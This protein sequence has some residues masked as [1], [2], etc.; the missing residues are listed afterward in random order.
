[1]LQ[2]LANRLVLTTR[3][4]LFALFLLI[5]WFY[6]MV[7]PPAV[8]AEPAAAA[9]LVSAGSGG[10]G[11]NHHSWTSD[12][13]AD[14]RLIAFRSR[15]TNLVA[16]DNTGAFFDIFVRDRQSGVT[17]RVSISSGG[18]PAN[19]ESESPAISGDGRVI[20]FSSLASNLVVGDH[21]E[22]ADVFVH[23]R[24]SG[25]TTRVSVGSGGTEGVLGGAAHPDLSSDGRFVVFESDAGNLIPSDTN[26]TT[27]IFGHDRATGVT[28]RLSVASDG[29]EG[30]TFSKLPSVSDNGQI[31]AFASQAFTLVNNDTNFVQDIFVRDR[32]NGLTT[33]VSVPSGGGQA[34]G[35]STN[36]AVSGDGRYVVFE[37]TATN[38]VVGDTNGS[39]DIFRHD[40]QTGQ[41]IRISTHQNG[42]EGNGSSGYPSISGDGRL[43]AFESAATNLVDTDPNGPI[44]DIFVKHAELDLVQLVTLDSSGQGS[45]GTSFWA[46]I[47][48]HGDWVT[49]SSDADDLT[50]GD[51]N[52]RTDVFVSEVEGPPPTWTLMFYMAADGAR[53]SEYPIIL[54]R[55]ESVAGSEAAELFVYFDGANPGD[56]AFYHVLPDFNPTSLASYVEGVNMFSLGEADFSDPS[57]LEQFIVDA[58]SRSATPHTAL[59]LDGYGHG[60]AGGM[61]D[62]DCAGSMSLV[63]LQTALA[64]AE[65]T[66][67]RPLDIVMGFANGMGMLEDAHLLQD[68]ASFWVA[69]PFEMTAWPAFYGDL[70]TSVAYTATPKEVAVAMATAYGD[71]GAGSKE[72]YAI[73]AVDLGEISGLVS[74]THDFGGVLQRALPTISPTVQSQVISPVQRYD[75]ETADLRHLAEL[76]RT[77]YAGNTALTDGAQQVIDQLDA[78]VL[79][80]RHASTTE[81]DLGNSG[82]MGIFLPQRPSLYYEEGTIPFALGG[83]SA[84]SSPDLFWGDFL[85]DYVTMAH[86]TAS[87]AAVPPIPTVKRSPYQHRNYLVTI[88]R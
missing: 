62:S 74:A 9:E 69:S 45:S 16:G 21:N 61:C 13:S 4:V 20:A 42:S 76:V 27:D 3:L 6:A 14:G 41:T 58:L 78:A 8:Q 55:L 35:P 17:Q 51:Q 49:F 79:F 38:L 88:I 34:N 80:E 12:S 31:V 72:A 23:D 82:G 73:A 11:A 24:S 43:I 48:S 44:P 65:S 84:G 15:A 25:Q 87:P 33:R 75:P 81:V 63:Q 36:P 64:G 22:R 68:R 71:V 57:V 2:P 37:S 46:A 66:T 83:W 28:T 85:V 29:S 18:Q 59:I 70:V 30:N 7:A 67:G 1:M 39:S 10:S 40:R 47:A 77:V 56:G 52:G 26:G 32:V 50:Q 86:P 54:N 5:L 60:L 53:S 19:G